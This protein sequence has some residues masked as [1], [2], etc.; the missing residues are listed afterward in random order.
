[1]KGGSQL[2]IWLALGGGSAATAF[3]FPGNWAAIIV[4]GLVVGLLVPF[5]MKGDPQAPRSLDARARERSDRTV[6]RIGLGCIAGGAMLLAYLFFVENIQALYEL[7]PR[8]ASTYPYVPAFLAGVG[9]NLAL[10]RF[11]FMYPDHREELK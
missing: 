2:V 5:V 9:G 3:L 4:L 1:M 7:R 11:R 6:L 8:L 10:T